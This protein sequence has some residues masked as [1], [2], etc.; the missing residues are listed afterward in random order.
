M[1]NIYIKEK[2]DKLK[3]EQE[4]EKLKQEKLLKLH[5]SNL[6]LKSITI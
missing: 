3:E 2:Q 4:K 6:E 5:K 1:Y